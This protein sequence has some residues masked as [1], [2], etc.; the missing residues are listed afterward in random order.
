[1]VFSGKLGL[2]VSN[3]GKAPAI[4]VVAYRLWNSD[5]HREPVIPAGGSVNMRT[6]WEAVTGS[7]E[8][9]P[10]PDDLPAQY[11]PAKKAYFLI[12]WSDG[13]AERRTTGWRLIPRT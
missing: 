7:E 3:T 11:D 4:D 12:S 10:V 1:V 8:F 9:P 6:S 13:A 2:V 5:V